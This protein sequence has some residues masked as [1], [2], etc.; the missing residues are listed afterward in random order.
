MKFTCPECKALVEKTIND[1]IGCPCCGY[2]VTTTKLPVKPEK[3]ESP[4][5]LEKLIKELQEKRKDYWYYWYPDVYF[6]GT[7]QHCGLPFSSTANPGIPGLT[8]CPGYHITWTT[9]TSTTLKL[10]KDKE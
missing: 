4:E 5:E 2:K 9:S 10:S 6:K 1:P 3:N 8:V 7:C